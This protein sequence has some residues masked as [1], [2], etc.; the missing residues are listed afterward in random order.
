MSNITLKSTRREI[1]AKK[2]TDR[3][4]RGAT[5]SSQIS[6]TKTLKNYQGSGKKIV[7]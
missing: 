6:R 1:I 5:L 7:K 3:K 2:L 4:K